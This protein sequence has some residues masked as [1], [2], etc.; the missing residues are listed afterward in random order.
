MT[1]SLFEGALKRE[2]VKCPTCGRP[3]SYYKGS[4]RAFL[5]C[6]DDGGCGYERSWDL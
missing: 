5:R 1:L 3:A 2:I 4:S 6:D